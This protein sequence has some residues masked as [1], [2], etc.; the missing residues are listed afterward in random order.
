MIL[1]RSSPDF[2]LLDPP[3]TPSGYPAGDNVRIISEQEF[4]RE[5]DLA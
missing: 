1:T 5:L 3:E 2:G 4:Q